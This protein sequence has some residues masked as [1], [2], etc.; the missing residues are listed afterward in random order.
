MSSRGISDGNIYPILELYEKNFTPGNQA[1]P[2]LKSLAYHKQYASRKSL[3]TRATG[4]CHQ[5][6]VTY[7]HR[8]IHQV[9]GSLV[10]EKKA[11]GLKVPSVQ[12]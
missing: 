8:L 12:T 7:P 2:R 3:S 5:I 11:K 9:G 1:I 4:L 6:G 10:R